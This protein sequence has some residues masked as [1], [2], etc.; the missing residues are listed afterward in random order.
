[1][2]GNGASEIT[3]DK[4]LIDGIVHHG[5]RAKISDEEKLSLGL[6][7]D[8]CGASTSLTFSKTKDFDCTKAYGTAL[9]D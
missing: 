8:W 1:M 5:A 7:D 6:G 9:T 4:G 2:S 3:C